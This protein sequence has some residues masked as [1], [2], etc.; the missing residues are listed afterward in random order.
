MDESNFKDTVARLKEVNEVVES[1]DSAIRAAAFEILSPYVDN[2]SAR[3]R[4]S[5]QRSSTKG[6]AKGRAKKATTPKRSAGKRATAAKPPAIPL[7][8][9]TSSMESFVRTSEAKKPSDY[10]YAIVGWWFS[11]YGSFP[12]TTLQ[13]RSMAT[14]IGVTLPARPDTTLLTATSD[15]KQLFRKS[16]EGIVPIVPHGELHL[17]QKYGIK[18]GKKALPATEP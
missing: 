2:A 6:S 8:I 3:S 13:I 15:G 5:S 9:D 7:D 4:R 12:I 10:V 18:K 16:G 17:T 11:E 1:L 14:E